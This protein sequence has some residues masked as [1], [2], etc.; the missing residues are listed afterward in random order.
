MGGHAVGVDPAGPRP[1]RALRPLRARRRPVRDAPGSMRGP[2]TSAATAGR[3]G[4]AATSSAGR[5]STTTSP[6]G[7]RPSAVAAGGRPVVLYG[8]SMG[9]LVAAGYLLSDRPKP[10]LAVLA[11]PGLDSALPG[12]KKTVS[13]R[14][15]E[16]HPD[17]RR[18]RTASTARR[19]RA[20]RRSAR[21]PPPIRSA[22]RPARPASAPRAW[23]SRHAFGLLRPAASAS[24]RWSCTASTTAWSR[25]A[26]SEVLEGAPGVERRTYPRP[27]PR[28][29]Q[30]TRRPR[31]HRRRDRLAE[32]PRPDHRVKRCHNAGPG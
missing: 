4:A 9:G 32:S 17:A 3:A 30:R 14:L 6:N 24:R 19:S 10:D 16:G 23:P 11:S 28:A 22:R 18:S 13:R 20:T 29:P 1:R 25:S 12:W 26:A 5:S 7:W 31:D 8:H 15:A 2:T 27:P 21:R